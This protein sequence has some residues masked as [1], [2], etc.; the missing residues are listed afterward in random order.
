MKTVIRLLSIVVFLSLLVGFSYSP[1]EAG[2][3]CQPLL[4]TSHTA[5]MAQS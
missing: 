1:V 4:R 3:R 5:L 2:V